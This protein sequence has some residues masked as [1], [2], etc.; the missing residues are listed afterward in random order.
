PG[1]QAVQA[2]RSVAGQEQGNAEKPAQPGSQGGLRGT[3]SPRPGGGGGSPGAEEEVT[4]MLGGASGST[5]TRAARRRRRPVC[6]RDFKTGGR[7][8]TGGRSGAWRSCGRCS[9]DRPSPPPAG[10]AVASGF[11]IR[12]KHPGSR[13]CSRHT[14]NSANPPDVTVLNL[15]GGE[16]GTPYQTA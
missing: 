1:P 14:R 8:C 7:S 12:S 13:S 4:V 16:G 15:A 9:L 2:S 6:G 3:T 5:G 11:D 10:W